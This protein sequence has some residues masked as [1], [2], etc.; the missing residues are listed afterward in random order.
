MGKRCSL[1]LWFQAVEHGQ[2][3][4]EVFFGFDAWDDELL[5]PCGQLGRVN[6]WGDALCGF[7][8]DA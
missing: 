5:R 8:R 3:F 1:A 2:H 7:Q 6:L 4:G